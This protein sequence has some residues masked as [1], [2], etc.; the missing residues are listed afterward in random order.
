MREVTGG[1]SKLCNGELHDLYAPA[2]FHY[3]D[4][5]K[6]NEMGG[7]YGMHGRGEMHTGV[8]WEYLKE[9]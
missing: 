2:A 6:E 8:W 3:G 4:Q 1:W 7:S 9:R 5:M